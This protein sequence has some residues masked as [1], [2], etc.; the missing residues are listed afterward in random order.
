MENTK[1]KI[2]I[3]MMLSTD[4]VIIHLSIIYNI[5]INIYLKIEF[6]IILLQQ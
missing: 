5:K 4:V 2:N 3:T 1:Y 6:V